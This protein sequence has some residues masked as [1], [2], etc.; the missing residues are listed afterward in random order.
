MELEKPI[1][2]HKINNKEETA[3]D[4]RPLLGDHKRCKI[5]ITEDLEFKVIIMQFLLILKNK[6]IFNEKL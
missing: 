3:P 4:G 6:K 1:T 5:S 2:T